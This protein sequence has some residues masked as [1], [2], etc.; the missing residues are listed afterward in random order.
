LCPSGKLES[1]LQEDGQRAT[2][3]SRD[4][5]RASDSGDASFESG[6]HRVDFPNYNPKRPDRAFQF[7]EAARE[8]H[9]RIDAD[10]ARGDWRS[11]ANIYGFELYMLRHTCLTRWAPFMDPWTLEYLA[12]H[13]DMNITRRYVHPQE[14]TI[15][16]A[17][18][19]ALC[20]RGA[21]STPQPLPR[22]RRFGASVHVVRARA[23]ETPQG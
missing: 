5:Q 2:P 18:L 14:Q 4:T 19:R 13:R 17:Y 1:L 6:Q 21:V 11:Q 8:G 3:Y 20:N 16:L 23:T 9:I 12:G 15:R 10:I 7:E 22:L